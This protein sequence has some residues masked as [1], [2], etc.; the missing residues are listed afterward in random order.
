[1][2]DE[3]DNKPLPGPPGR[4]QRLENGPSENL[5]S[6]QM[7]MAMMEG[8]LDEFMKE[9][10]PDSD[11]ARALAMMMAGMTGMITPGMPAPPVNSGPEKL[12]TGSA[13]TQP[14]GTC[15]DKEAA[16]SLPEGVIEA[17]RGGDVKGLMDLLEKEHAK[18]QPEQ[19]G[20]VAESPDSS[21]QA[22][23]EKD[24]V[25]SLIKI[26]SENGLSTD[27]LILRALKLY[28]QEY[29]KTGRL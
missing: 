9:K 11:H 26:A 29:L 22:V 15:P 23:I 2:P 10:I 3:K 27:W 4:K 5:L 20:L 19:V 7:S 1:M 16:S 24:V 8:R 21:P 28:V 18:R 25:D 12:E 13:K 14:P 6:E 17:V